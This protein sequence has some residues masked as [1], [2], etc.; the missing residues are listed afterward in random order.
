MKSSLFQLL[1]CLCLFGSHACKKDG[2]PDNYKFNGEFTLSETCS[3][4]G[5]AGYVVV[6]E[7]DQ[8][9]EQ[10]FSIKGLWEVP[11]SK[12]VCVIDKK[13]AYTFSLARQPLGNSGFDIE[14]PTGHMDK[15][16]REV[17]GAYTIY[18]GQTVVESCT[19]SAVAK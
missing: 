15:T 18:S 3:A 7:L 6:F 17:T 4:S 9:D 13:D 16:T 8:S 5:A 12:S 14:M 11:A 1:L 10:K 19:F 2:D